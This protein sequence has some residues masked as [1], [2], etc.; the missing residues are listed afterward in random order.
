M[1]CARWN[2]PSWTV[3]EKNED[4]QAT[5]LPLHTSAAPDTVS[6]E[7]VLV[8]FDEQHTEELDKAWLGADE[9]VIDIQQRKLLD[10]N[11]IRVGVIRGDLPKE[12]LQQLELSR[13]QQRTDVEEQLGLASDSDSRARLLSC[14]GGKRKELLIRRENQQPLSVVTTIGGSVSGHQFVRASALFALTM[15][16]QTDGT[17]ITELI[18]E[19]Q[20]G[21]ARQ[22]FISGEFGM[23][24]ELRRDSKLWKQL[25]IRTT[26]A[27]NEVL[28]VSTT[29]PSKALGHAF[30]RTEN[31]QQIE[32]QIVLLIRL[33]STSS[34]DLFSD[35]IVGQLPASVEVR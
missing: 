24:Q 3:P 29:A 7:T 18:P 32:E 23:R 20:Y 27:T 6:V 34:D 17:A 26:L 22:N 2:R 15:Y 4:S 14:R 8:R 28:M 30:F 16:P 10:L 12:I 1:G 5:T 31:S 25:K 9:S 21:D 13:S 11:G 33:A 19:I 35:T